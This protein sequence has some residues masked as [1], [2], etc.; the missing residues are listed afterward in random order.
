MNGIGSIQTLSN[1]NDG[2]N[3]GHEEFVSGIG[4]CKSLNIYSYTFNRFEMEGS[5]TQQQIEDVTQKRVRYADIPAKGGYTDEYWEVD[6]G[7][8]IIRIRRPQDPLA[9]LR[10]MEKD[11]MNVSVEEEIAEI[12]EGLAE[13]FRKRV[14]G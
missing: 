1:R 3:L 12:R 9:D 10:E 6:M 7:N 8:E 11:R 14:E 5:I 4:G 13:E 2:D